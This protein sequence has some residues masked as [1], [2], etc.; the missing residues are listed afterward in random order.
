MQLENKINIIF[1]CFLQVWVTPDQELDG[2][3]EFPDLKNTRM[4]W[5]TKSCYQNEW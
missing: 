2:G 4:H 3:I 5:K 1:N